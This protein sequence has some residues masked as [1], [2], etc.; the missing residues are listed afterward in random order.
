MLNHDGYHA[1]PCWT[2]ARCQ[3]NPSGS[4]KGRPLQSCSGHLWCSR[5]LVHGSGDRDVLLLRRCWSVGF[6]SRPACDWD[7]R[8]RSLWWFHCDFTVISLW[9]HCDYTNVKS[10]TNLMHN[11]IQKTLSDGIVAG[12]Q[13]KPLVWTMLA[14]WSH[15]EHASQSFIGVLE[16]LVLLCSTADWV[17]F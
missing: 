11:R 10:W 1:E 5:P 7:T 17:L 13:T 16:V 6:Q 4:T 15:L 12:T 2:K 9:F 14:A 8:I 3:W